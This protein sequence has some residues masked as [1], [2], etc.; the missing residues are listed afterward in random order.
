MANRSS[1]RSAKL[2]DEADIKYDIDMPFSSRDSEILLIEQN[3][4]EVEVIVGN[5]PEPSGYNLDRNYPENLED[6]ENMRRHTVAEW[7]VEETTEMFTDYEWETSEYKS[8]NPNY[9]L[10]DVYFTCDKDELD[11]AVL[12]A[13]TFLA[14]IE[15]KAL[16]HA[17][18]FDRTYNS[19]T[20]D[21]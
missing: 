4:D 5:I 11:N 10:R 14:E 6:E 16:S 20:D 12:T 3:D 21:L 18:R 15:R 9:H 1:N 2:R 19:P 13:K 7:I 8:N 17:K